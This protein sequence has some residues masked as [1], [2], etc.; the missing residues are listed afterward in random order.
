M[1][2]GSY[3]VHERLGG[4]RA[5]VH[6]GT[7]PRSGRS[8]VLKSATW[9]RPAITAALAR[10]AAILRRVRHPSL[11][12]LID[13]VEDLDGRTLVLG[14][15][16]QGDL[17][18]VLAVGGPLEPGRAADL[19]RCVAAALAALHDH[20]IVHRDVRPSNVVI[21]AEL[22]PVLCD[23]DHA[24]DPSQ[25]RLDS[26]GDVVG[27][28]GHVDP[29]VLDGKPQGPA[30]D[31]FGLGSV[32]WAA[33]SGGLPRPDDVGQAAGTLPPSLLA[34]IEACLTGTVV[35]ARTAA[36][37][38]EAA[39]ADAV[40]WRP[41]VAS[42][43]PRAAAPAGP[44][45]PRLDAPRRD[46]PRAAGA[47]D[48]VGVPGRSGDDDSIPSSTAHADRSRAAPA[49]TRGAGER[50]RT[51]RWPSPPVAGDD[52]QDQPGAGR[53]ARRRLVVGVAAGAAVAAGVVV[54]STTIGGTSPPVAA[55]SPTVTATPTADAGV[56][57]AR[58]G[59]A[60][61]P[62]SPPP[63]CPDRGTS[64]DAA[65]STVLA[66][67]SGRGCSVTLSLRDGVLTS[68]SGRHAVGQDGDQLVAGDWD[69]DGQWSPGVYRP[70]TGEVF[71][72]D[73]AP[74]AGRPLTSRPAEQHAPDG[75]A[76]VIAPGPEA[77]HEVV[78]TP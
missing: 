26:D 19:G 40:A 6:R 42:P 25:P 7:D 77:R 21:D 52:P 10:E 33:A 32:V 24:L 36:S 13:V 72:F 67:T 69:G 70:G 4:S 41:S 8:V 54:A 31:L 20:S 27:D 60:L 65:A 37:G 47:D 66:D 48:T 2:A 11:V 76:V 38:F 53:A 63:P 30:M 58:E 22:V 56:D 75:I 46:D 14:H 12:E 3:V 17:T 9:D 23:L 45:F 57:T 59:P 71:L 28:A 49:G 1:H 16:A 51:H 34:A 5:A 64:A 74:A 39:A 35:D 29:R 68:P 15:G 61:V 18:R 73:S 43:R 44:P 50:G 55:P 62:V 78:V